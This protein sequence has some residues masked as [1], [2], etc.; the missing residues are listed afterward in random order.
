MECF[1]EMTFLLPLADIL[2]VVAD[3]QNVSNYTYVIAEAGSFGCA[4]QMTCI[5]W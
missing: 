3:K 1:P 4:V 5:V 2:L